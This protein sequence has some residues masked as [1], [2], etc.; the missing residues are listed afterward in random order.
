M[1]SHHTT[2]APPTYDG[3]DDH[4][5]VED[6]PAD[7]E[8]VAAQRQDLDEAFG[9]EEHDERQVDLVEHRLHALR[10]LVRLHHHGH[11]VDDD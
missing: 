10:L 1:T 11:H 8:E 4:H 6:V 5:K 9:G 3:E 2:G 7:G